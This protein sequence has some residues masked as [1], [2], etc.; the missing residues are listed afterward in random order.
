MECVMV[1]IGLLLVLVS[2]LLGAGVALSNTDPVSASAFGVSLSNV[3]V[4][5]L[6]LVGAA[7][8]VV[9]MLGLVIAVTGAGRQRSKR[10]GI[11]AQ[12]AAERDRRKSLAQENAD[13]HEQLQRTGATDVA[14]RHGRTDGTP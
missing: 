11:K 1:A 4:G 7:T 12:A 3:S 5:G 6:F 9:F 14:A 10:R 2:G 13:L 8:G